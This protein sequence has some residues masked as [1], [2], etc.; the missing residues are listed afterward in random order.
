MREHRQ[1]KPVEQDLRQIR[2]LCN[3]FASHEPGRKDSQ[4][5][6]AFFQLCYT[7]FFF[8]FQPR[9]EF[10]SFDKLD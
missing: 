10:G 5:P 3:Y 1:M 4:P 6:K 9:F 2:H 7:Q 8:G